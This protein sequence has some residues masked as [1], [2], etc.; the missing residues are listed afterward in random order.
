MTAIQKDSPAARFINRLAQKGKGTLLTPVL[1]EALPALGWKVERTTALA[2][3]PCEYDRQGRTGRGRPHPSAQVVERILA[4]LPAGMQPTYVSEYG[5]WHFKDPAFPASL[6][7]VSTLGKKQR[8]KDVVEPPLGV[9]YSSPPVYQ[10]W[11]SPGEKAWEVDKVYAGHHALALTSPSGERQVFPL[12][13]S[14]TEPFAQ[15]EPPAAVWTFL[16]NNGAQAAAQKAVDKGLAV[17]RSREE[18]AREAAFSEGDAGTC[19]AC[20]NVQKV[21]ARTDPPTLVLH[22]YE[23]PGYGWIQGSCAGVGRYP[24]EVSPHARVVHV[25]NLNRWL[26]TLESNLVNQPEKLLVQPTSGSYHRLFRVFSD[27]RVEKVTAGGSDGVGRTAFDRLCETS[28]GYVNSDLPTYADALDLYRRNVRRQIDL[29]GRDLRDLVDTLAKWEPSLDYAFVPHGEPDKVRPRFHDAVRRYY[30]IVV[31]GTPVTDLAD[32]AA[33][34][35]PEGLADVAAMLP[36]GRY[37]AH[38]VGT[39]VRPLLSPAHAAPDEFDPAFRE[40]DVL[41][42]SESYREPCSVV[43]KVAYAVPNE[44]PLNITVE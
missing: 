41:A 30:A 39:L 15:L 8:P 4:M 32:L 7:P 42:P 16:Y 40:G 25:E 18:R 44:Q 20:G 9:L 6:W 11:N 21:N 29:I 28:V 24:W 23:R 34:A 22:G 35:D 37:Q 31:E 17:V 5:G 43:A 38:L 27:G 10:G 13:F 33:M 36:P 1:E 12:P 14:S 3:V 26:K 19:A 2:V